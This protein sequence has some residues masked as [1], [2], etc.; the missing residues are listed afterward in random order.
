M[1]TYSP[2][3]LRFFVASRVLSTFIKNQFEVPP[4]GGD[5]EPDLRF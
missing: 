4:T 2:C 1:L 5:L 3:M